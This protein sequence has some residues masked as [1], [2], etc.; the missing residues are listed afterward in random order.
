[1]DPKETNVAAKRNRYGLSRYIPADIRREVRERSKYGC[2]ICRNA[3]YEYEHI[4][5]IWVD[6]KVHGPDHIC[7]LCGTCHSKV[8]KQH[9]SKDT[10]LEAYQKGEN[11]TSV[12]RPFS[13][14]DLRSRQ[15]VV[16]LGKCKFTHSRAIFTID[17]VD[18]L[19][20]MIP[21]GGIGFP[22]LNG[23]FCDDQG[24][25]IFKIKNNQ[26]FGPLDCW[27]MKIVANKITIRS[28]PQKIALE[29]LVQPPNEIEIVSLDMRLGNCR[30]AVEDLLILERLD[31]GRVFRMG[32]EADCVGSDSC[33]YINST[34]PK[35]PVYSE[36]RMVGGQG[37]EL[38]DCGIIVGK[39]SGQAHIRRIK[40]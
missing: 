37:I 2:V 1:M 13:D 27:D 6:A 14:F 28:N 10:V 19:S 20:F 17:S 24:Y 36:L 16:K 30:V 8:T 21:E 9:L 3:I 12:K 34:N 22:Q 11:D 33:V 7:L 5:P 38:F 32:V 18:L 29:L 31:D 39:G 4:D 35:T 25:E 23:I 40:N 26:W 15:L